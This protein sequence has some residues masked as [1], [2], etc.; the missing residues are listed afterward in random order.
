MGRTVHKVLGPAEF[1]P[2]IHVEDLVK[3]LEETLENLDTRFLDYITFSGCGEPTLHPELGDMIE[4]VRGKCPSVPIAIL[5]NSSL[6]WLEEVAEAA[7]K[8]DFVVAKLDSAD[9]TTFKLINRPAEG[10]ELEMVLEGLRELRKKV[11]GRLAIQSMFLKAH[12]KPLNTG[13]E[14]LEVFSEALR[15]IG[16]DQVQVNTPTRPP[17]EPYVEALTGKELR[18]VADFLSSTLKGIEVISWHP[19]RPGPVRKKAVGL[20]Q[21]ILA[22]L[23]RRPCRFHELCLST[24]AEPMMIRAELD[25]LISDGLVYVRDYRGER[26]YALRA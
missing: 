23:E 9:P 17:A 3:G 11:R 25:R 13:K 7:S 4:V 21:A 10:I 15:S 22:I 2:K 6:F 14:D 1:K 16:P 5:T 12:G 26:F 24:D 18:A 19:P 20:R 8:A